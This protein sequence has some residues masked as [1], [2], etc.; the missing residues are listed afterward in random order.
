VNVLPSLKENKMNKVP[1]YLKNFC[2]DTGAIIKIIPPQKKDAT[3]GCAW[4]VVILI[5]MIICFIGFCVYLHY[6]G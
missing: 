5:P 6:F 3:P 4:L 1:E 2:A